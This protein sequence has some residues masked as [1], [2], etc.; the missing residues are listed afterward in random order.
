MFF[1]DCSAD[2]KAKYR[3]AASLRAIINVKMAF[4]TAGIFRAT[5]YRSQRV[6]RA[7]PERCSVCRKNGR[8][9]FRC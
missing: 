9:F 1:G 6:L 7:G 3:L 8:E 4:E 5:H 2:K